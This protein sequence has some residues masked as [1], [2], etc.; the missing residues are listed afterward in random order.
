MLAPSSARI[1]ACNVLQD[2]SRGDSIAYAT[3]AK[4]MV[5]QEPGLDDW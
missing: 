5:V 3:E 1:Y 2:I 4:S